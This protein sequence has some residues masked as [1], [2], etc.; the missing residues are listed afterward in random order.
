MFTVF[1]FM[2]Q[3]CNSYGKTS[4][5]CIAKFRESYGSEFKVNSTIHPNAEMV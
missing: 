4:G 2:F 3:S 5:Q 1:D